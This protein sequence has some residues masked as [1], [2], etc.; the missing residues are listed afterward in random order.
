MNFQ[1]SHTHAN[2]KLVKSAFFFLF[3]RNKLV[4]IV[5]AFYHARRYPPPPLPQR[6]ERQKGRTTSG[7]P[8]RLL[9]MWGA[10]PQGTENTV[11][12]W[13]TTRRERSGRHL[14]EETLRRPQRPTEMFEAEVDV[15]WLW[16]YLLR[17][18][19]CLVPKNWLTI[20]DY[21]VPPAPTTLRII[22]GT[23]QI[24]NCHL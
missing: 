10:N 19:Y 17:T 6:K 23:N 11:H 22:F 14:T 12:L 7:E 1:L 16:V 3:E 4:F 8:N 24:K 13:A 21:D 2:F 9:V 20:S 15:E 18:T 5:E